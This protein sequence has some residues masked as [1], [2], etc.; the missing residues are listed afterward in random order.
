M[1]CYYINI[2]YK[3]TKIHSFNIIF[4]FKFNMEKLQSF[5]SAL[6]SKITVVK[7]NNRKPSKVV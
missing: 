3:G 1:Y 5:S 2:I 4:I 6:L 7:I